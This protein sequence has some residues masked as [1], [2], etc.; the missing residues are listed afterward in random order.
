MLIKPYAPVIKKKGFQPAPVAGNIPLYADSITNPKVIGTKNY[1]DFWNEQIDRCIN[2]Y[3]TAGVH[4]SGRY[5]FYLNFNVLRGLKGLQY[6]FYIDLDLEYY[7]LVEYV[8]INRKTGIISIKARRKGLSEKAKLILS[9][10]LRFTEGYRGAVTAGIETYVTGLRNKFEF[11]Q[12]SIIQDLRL[13]TL[14]NNEK[15]YK[16]G[17]DIK[18]P[19]GGYVE[20]GYGGFISFETMYDDPTKLEGEYFHDVICEESGRYKH[21]GKTVSSIL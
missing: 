7:D 13:N 9:H 14:Q 15:V 20:D 3:D 21:L 2:G 18:N 8:K 10:G 1:E 11:A 5:Y 6:P 4:V 16:I 17:Y 12:S 19:I